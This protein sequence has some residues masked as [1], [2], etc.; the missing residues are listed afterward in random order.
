MAAI[1]ISKRRWVP[2]DDAKALL[3]TIFSADSFPTLSVRSQLAQQLGLCP[4]PSAARARV[5]HARP[6]PESC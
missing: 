6:P 4:R 3:E 2:S 1:E 5:P